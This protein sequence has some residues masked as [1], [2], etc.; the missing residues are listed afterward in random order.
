LIVFH[1]AVPTIC[2]V[3]CSTSQAALDIPLTVA[4]TSRFTAADTT[5]YVPPIAQQPKAGSHTFGI[6]YAKTLTCDKLGNLSK[7][8]LWREFFQFRIHHF[9]ISFQ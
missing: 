1:F 9:E 4:G 8:K 6:A 5:Q 3:S 2:V 7:G